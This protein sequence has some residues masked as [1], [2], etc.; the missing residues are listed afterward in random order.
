MSE[1]QF[2]SFKSDVICCGNNGRL[3]ISTY[4]DINVFE[5]PTYQYSGTTDITCQFNLLD[6]SINYV[7]MESDILTQCPGAADCVDTAEWLI[8]ISE[9]GTS[10]YSNLINTTNGF[11]G[12]TISEEII[13]NSVKEGFDTLGYEYINYD[14]DFFV[15]RPFG[16]TT[17][18]VGICFDILLGTGGTCTGGTCY[19]CYDIDTTAYS[20]LTSGSTGVYIYDDETE[21]IPIT[22][23]F[24][25]QTV[26]QF[27]GASDLNVFYD[28]FKFRPERNKFTKPQ[29][30]T[31]DSI[32]W[33]SPIT[34]S[35]TSYT[36]TVTI[37]SIGGEGEY[38]VRTRHMFDAETQFR[39]LFGEKIASQRK[40]TQYGL[41]EPNVD[42]YFIA[43]KYADEPKF[44]AGTQS[45]PSFGAL[46]VASIIVSSGNTGTTYTLGGGIAGDIMVDLN[47][48]GLT[49]GTDYNISGMTA[50][51]L[52]SLIG[53]NNAVI[54]LTSPTVSGDVLTFV[55]S[56]SNNSNAF[57]NDIINIFAIT[58]GVTGGQGNNSIYFNT[59]T[60]KYEAYTSMT[61]VDSGDIYVVLNGVTLANDIDYYRSSSDKRRVI[62]DGIL[63]SGDTLSMYYQ[64]VAKVSGE[65]YSLTQS[66]TW[67]IDTRP[68][69]TGSEFVLEVADDES[70]S[71]VT[72]SST[73]SHIV[74]VD[75]YTDTLSLSGTVNDIRYYR[76]RNNKN[77]TT[78][79]GDVISTSAVSEVVPIT[80]MTAS[81]NNY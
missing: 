76:V 49:V 21:T 22:I 23:A 52:G 63:M 50:L 48:I 81:V 64:P 16:V 66:V 25:P 32:G 77:Y 40:E 37:G 44:K 57:K 8:T 39:R 59:D 43:V 2:H 10:A 51:E 5:T 18:S 14:N 1:N 62:F 19:S 55:Y 42:G 58:S 79:C 65:A 53:R 26:S 69:Q 27:S 9:D 34:Q 38:S 28:V 24:P 7:L 71:A 45:D 70:F 3:A 20:T 6:L 67:F 60:G 15:K 13:Q 29:R 68:T 80:I 33:D 4:S 41:Y 61:P 56:T 74:G 17:L 11:T 78:V 72:Y 36:E 35:L 54:T 30:Y 73:T 12:E 75:T 31:S 46:R 47:G